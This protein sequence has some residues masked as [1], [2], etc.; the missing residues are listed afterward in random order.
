MV[1]SSVKGKRKSTN[2]PKK[3]KKPKSEKAVLN[4][5]R[6]RIHLLWTWYSPEVKKAESRAQISYKL[7]GCESCGDILHY[8]Q[9][10][11]DHIDPKVPID[12]NVNDLN[13]QEYYD[14]TNCKADNIM[15]LCEKCHSEKSDN[16]N[17]LRL[18][19]RKK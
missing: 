1:K 9:I 2:A 19:Y 7:W 5:I 3:S 15:V 16:E 18:E 13:L 10:Q 14:R 17:Q 11:R 12:M 8:G 6:A 4:D